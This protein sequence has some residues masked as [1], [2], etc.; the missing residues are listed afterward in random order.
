MRW[1]VILFLFIPTL[2]FGQIDSIKH[3]EVVSELRD[4]MVLLQKSDVDK[5]NKVFFERNQLD[6]LNILNEEIILNLEHVNSTLDSIIIN[7]KAIIE[8]HVEIESSLTK[9]LK[10]NQDF[11]QDSLKK[12]RREKIGWQT[13]TGISIL[14]ILLILLL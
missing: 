11:Y 7:Q 12:S 3:V 14:A 2:L 6:S 13:S 4:S 1:F 5:I 10:E 9:E 8:N